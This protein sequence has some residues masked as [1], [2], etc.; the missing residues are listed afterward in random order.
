M[1][2]IEHPRVV[3]CAALVKAWLPKIREAQQSL[4]PELR[5]NSGVS[6]QVEFMETALWLCDSL[7]PA[8]QREPTEDAAKEVVTLRL[9]LMAVGELLGGS[10]AMARAV[11]ESVQRGHRLSNAA[12][13]Q[14]EL[15]LV[16]AWR[17]LNQLGVREGPDGRPLPRDPEAPN[18][19]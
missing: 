16:D 2:P 4:P 9:L 7:V 1:K 18:R 12:R 14:A 5:T 8:L 3:R 15:Y 19:G 6:E 13:V 17:L 10:V 11:V